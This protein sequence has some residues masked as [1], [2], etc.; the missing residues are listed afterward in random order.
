MVVSIARHSEGF[1]AARFPFDQKALDLLRKMSCRR[2]PAGEKARLVPERFA[3]SV[4]SRRFQEFLGHSDAKATIHIPLCSTAV[5][6]ECDAA[7]TDF[8]IKELIGGQ[9]KLRPCKMD[10]TFKVSRP[11]EL[12]D[13]AKNG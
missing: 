9:Y 2:R 3:Y 13:S 6:R 8:E 4:E 12:D 1:P 11:K 7:W 5:P 10:Y